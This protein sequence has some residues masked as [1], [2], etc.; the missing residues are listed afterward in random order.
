MRRNRA[1]V[2]NITVRQPLETLHLVT[3]VYEIPVILGT[4]S[5]EGNMFVYAAYPTI[6]TKVVFQAVLYGFFRE[7]TT[8]VLKAYSG[9]V[10]QMSR[11]SHPDYRVALSQMIGD[12]LFR[13]PNQQFAENLNILNFMVYLYEFTMPTKVPNFPICDGLSCHTC[14]IPYVFGNIDVVHKN[15]SWKASTSI[16]PQHDVD[17]NLRTSPSWLKLLWP[18]MAVT[19]S[20][21]SVDEKLVDLMCSYWISFAAS[22][23]PTNNGN[24]WPALKTASSPLDRKANNLNLKLQGNIYA[25]FPILV[26]KDLMHQMI[27]SPNSNVMIIEND[28]ICEFWGQLGYKF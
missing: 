20:V 15:F 19:E 22:G 26:R 10:S 18:P 13:C 1:P 25:R 14:E 2:C 17:M 11:L 12:Y 5:H 21:R 7:S 9:L 4:N 24:W 8:K 3:T 27:F 16:L 28:C 6:M 23:T